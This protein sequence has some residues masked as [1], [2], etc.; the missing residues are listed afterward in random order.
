MILNNSF[1]KLIQILNRGKFLQFLNDSYFDSFKR[2][3]EFDVLGIVPN[4]MKRSYGIKEYSNVIPLTEILLN[5][6]PIHMDAFLYKIHA[7]MKMKM[8][9]KAMSWNFVQFQLNCCSTT[10]HLKIRFD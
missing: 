3:L 4:E 9:Q 1:R 2:D 6:D 5:I 10:I 8:N 7:L